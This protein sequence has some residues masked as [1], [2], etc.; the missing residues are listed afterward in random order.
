MPHHPYWNVERL[1]RENTD[2]TMLRFYIQIFGQP[3]LPPTDHKTEYSGAYKSQR[4]APNSEWRS[5]GHHRIGNCEFLFLE[6]KE[7]TLNRS[8]QLGKTDH[9]IY[10]F[11]PPEEED[12]SK[13]RTSQRADYSKSIRLITK[14]AVSKSALAIMT[15]QQTQVKCAELPIYGRPPLS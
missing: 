14:K 6:N 1:Y 11:V 5:W 9:L 15:K 7:E 2:R 12:K 13:E 3:L 8:Q 10:R 4:S